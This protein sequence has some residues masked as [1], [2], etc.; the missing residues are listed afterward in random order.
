MEREQVRK[1]IYE[2]LRPTV[3]EKGFRFKK[4]EGFVRLIPEGRQIIGVPFIDRRP[5]FE[6]CFTVSIGLKA[7]AKIVNLL[8]GVALQ[9]RSLYYTTITQPEYFVPNGPTR[10]RVVNEQDIVD[11][12]IAVSRILLERVFPFLDEY[13]TVKAID[14][15]VN[16][17]RLPGF[18][19]SVW[20]WGDHL[21]IAHLAG[22][23]DFDRLEREF[24]TEM[25]E[26]TPQEERDKFET[27]VA[28][29]R[30]SRAGEKMG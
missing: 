24:R 19:T 1:L 28:Y 14:R 20:P 27:L 21:T 17:E 26:Q 8:S 6:F 9:Y 5:E 11:G 23:P 12:T 7:V 3:S 22:N 16:R 30:L 29:L 15:A 10:F 13:Q 25:L 18:D 2:G 4:G